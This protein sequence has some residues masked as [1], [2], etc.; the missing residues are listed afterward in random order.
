MLHDVV[1]SLLD[2]MTE[3]VELQHQLIIS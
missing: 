2:V 3:Y 1:N